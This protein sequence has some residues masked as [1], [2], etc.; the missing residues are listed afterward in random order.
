[1][2]HYFEGPESTHTAQAIHSLFSTQHGVYIMEPRVDV[3][4]G[5]GGIWS[6]IVWEEQNKDYMLYKVKE[7]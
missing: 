7:Q 2:S 3:W 4:P 6:K 5:I 1:M